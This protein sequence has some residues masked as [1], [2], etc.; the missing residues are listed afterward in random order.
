MELYFHEQTRHSNAMRQTYVLPSNNNNNLSNIVMTEV[1]LHKNND[2]TYY[3]S[4]PSPSKPQI[5]IKSI[6]KLTC[7]ISESGT[8]TSFGFVIN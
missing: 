6:R 8:V 1:I 2:N 4:P 5:F 3:V 7:K